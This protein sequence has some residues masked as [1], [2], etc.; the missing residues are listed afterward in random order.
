LKIYEDAG[1][2]GVF[3]GSSIG[4][5]TTTFAGGNSVQ[6][7]FNSLALTDNIE[8]TAVVDGAANSLLYNF[9]DPYMLANDVY[10]DGGLITN[11]TD[12]SYYSTV[13]LVFKGNFSSATPV[14]FEFDP[15]GGLLVLGGGWLLRR[16]LKK[17]KYTKV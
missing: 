6:W 7:N 1:N 17:K 10:K 4:S 3:K 2:A 15:T 11:G 9:N 8:Y 16:H 14:P 13:D 5:T 12:A